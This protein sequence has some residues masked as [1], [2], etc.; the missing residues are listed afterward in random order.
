MTLDKASKP[1]GPNASKKAEFG[2]K[3]AAYGCVSLMIFKQ[4]ASADAA[5]ASVN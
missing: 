3:A 4:N 2:L 5:V 1:S